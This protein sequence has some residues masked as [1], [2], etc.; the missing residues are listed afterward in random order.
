VV[1]EEGEA[2]YRC[3]NADC[4]AKLRETLLHF[5]RREVMN[6]EGLGEAVVQQLLDRGLVRGVAD[7]YTLTE[8]QLLG[9]D[10]FAEKSAQALLAEIA[11]SKRAGLARVLMGLGIRFVGER[12]AELLAAEFGSMD[13]LMAATAEELERVEEVGP[14]ISQAILEFFLAA[15]NRALVENLQH[16]GV[17]MTAEKKQRTAQLAG[18]TFVLTGTL[19]TLTRD[20]AKQKIENAGG[21]TAGSVSKKTS[22]L[23]AGEEAG[24]KLD[25]ARELNIPVLDEAG[26]LALLAGQAPPR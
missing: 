2:D 8:E 6:I 20:E 4:P 12:T 7:L 14:R 1:R 26:L 9:L 5:G 10:R 22:Y 19:P 21:K 24:S 16:A 17:E 13:A 15:A 18:L 11:G 3:V 25:K 23:V